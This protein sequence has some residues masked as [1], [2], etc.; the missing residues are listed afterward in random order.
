M[1]EEGEDEEEGKKECGKT[2]GANE[3]TTSPPLHPCEEARDHAPERH[4]LPLRGHLVFFPLEH[5]RPNSTTSVSDGQEERDGSATHPVDPRPVDFCF[6][7][8]VPIKAAH[9][10][11]QPAQSRSQLLTAN[12]TTST[13]VFGG[14]SQLIRQSRAPPL[15]M[16]ERMRFGVRGS[17]FS[18]EQATS[19][20]GSSAVN[21]VVV[22]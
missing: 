13:A 10:R 20:L 3:E 9:R 11:I 16:E 8:S 7:A 18:I 14:E 15:R 1:D 6:R 5:F 4:A 22:V 2:S 21:A 19:T 17:F 12:V